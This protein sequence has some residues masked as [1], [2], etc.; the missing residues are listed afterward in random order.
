MWWRSRH[1]IRYGKQSRTKTNTHRCQSHR[2]S[3]SQQRRRRRQQHKRINYLRCDDYTQLLYNA[4]LIRCE[5]VFSERLLGSIHL[6]AVHR[7]HNND[8]QAT[9]RT[10]Q[11]K[12]H[13]Y[14]RKQKKKH[15]AMSLCV[16][17]LF[18]CVSIMCTFLSMTD[19]SEASNARNIYCCCCALYSIRTAC[20]DKRS[21]LCSK[22]KYFQC[23]SGRA[24]KRSC[25]IWN[26][27]TY[28]FSSLSLWSLCAR[29]TSSDCDF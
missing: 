2:Q 11:Y 7:T 17:L 10:R 16:D 20:V 23:Y 6:C 19:D 28:C 12:I 9:Q 18:L 5:C 14:Y 21:Q 22:Q 3:A 13:T 8:E 15:T 26:E 24:S 29:C 4:S 27:I 1:K 25:F